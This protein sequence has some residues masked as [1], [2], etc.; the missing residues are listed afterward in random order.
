[1]SRARPRKRRL[2]LPL[3][4]ALLTLTVAGASAHAAPIVNGDFETGGTGWT[5]TDTVLGTNFCTVGLCGTG[6]GTAGPFGGSGW[7]W[8][9]GSTLAQT[10]IVEQ[11]GVTLP[12]G[13]TLDFL[14]WVGTGEDPSYQFSVLVDGNSLFAIGFANTA[15][16]AS[17]APVSLSLGALADGGSH[18]IR[19]QYSDHPAGFVNTNVSLDNVSIN[20]VVNAPISSVPEPS[21]ILSLGLGLAATRLRRRRS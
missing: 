15:A 5:D 19:F 13:S 3:L 6:S 20:S 2:G 14:L 16:Y 17:Y 7:M 21:T 12:T 9:G 10:G 1:M 4:L 18:T 11:A 8:F